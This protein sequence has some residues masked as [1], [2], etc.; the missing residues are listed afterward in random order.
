MP[1]NFMIYGAYGYTGELT[2]RYAVEQ[3][4]RPILAGRNKTALEALGQRYDLET[5]P[6]AL[7]NPDVLDAALQDINVVIHAA[8]PFKYTFRQMAQACLRTKTHYLDITGEPTVYQTL[9]ALDALAKEAGIMLLPG[10]GFDVVPTDCLAAHLKNRLPSA[11]HLTLAFKQFG[12]A[13]FSQGTMKT[14]N[15]NM[16]LTDYIRQAGEWV[17]VPRLSKKRKFDFGRGEI[18]LYRMTWGDSITAYYSTGIPNIEN[19]FGVTTLGMTVM[20]M[21]KYLRPL[22][23]TP[24]M[25]TLFKTMIE[26]LP[27]GSTDE[28]IEKSKVVVWGEVKDEVGNTAVSRLHTPEAYR[29]TALTSLLAVNRILAGDAPTGYHTPATAYGPDFVLEAE[30]VTREDL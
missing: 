21:S 19:Y 1:T 15:E 4:L 27:L 24:F 30:G 16:A 12:P 20:K 10:I 8:G 9:H 2:T 13:Q 28:Q 14:A 25:K 6:F 26:L 18:A 3:G 5:R 11:T 23:G 7:D 17:S 29:L 22:M